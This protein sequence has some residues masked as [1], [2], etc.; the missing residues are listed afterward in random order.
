M[1]SGTNN[2]L[3]WLKYLP[4]LS[5]E[6]PIAPDEFIPKVNILFT[7]TFPIKLADA[8]NTE[9]FLGKHYRSHNHDGSCVAYMSG[10][11]G[12]GPGLRLC[13]CRVPGVLRRDMRHG[14]SGRQT[15][16]ECTWPVTVT[17]K[18]LRNREA[19]NTNTQ[20]ENSLV[21][22]WSFIFDDNHH[23]PSPVVFVFKVII[24]FSYEWHIN[25]TL[26]VHIT[27]Y[28]QSSWYFPIYEIFKCHIA[29]AYVFISTRK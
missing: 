21:S 24:I 17:D 16:A 9:V 29:C 10:K 4:F 23:S 7:I 13:E 25:V 15:R 5:Q 27:L 12:P 14:P 20:G 19:D 26:R 6:K 1:F 28:L 3:W 22:S 2:Y 11:P 18:Q 8:I